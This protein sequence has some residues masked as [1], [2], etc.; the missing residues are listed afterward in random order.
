VLLWPLMG[1]WSVTLVLGLGFASLVAATLWTFPELRHGWWA[2][3]ALVNPALVEGL[4]LG[5][6]PFLW[7][8]AMF[9]AAIGCWRNNKRTAAIVLAAL[10][11]LTHAPVLIP[12]VA[13]QAGAPSRLAHQPR[14]RGAGCDRR[15]L[16]TRVGPELG[17]V[18]DVDRGRD[19]HA[20][21]T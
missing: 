11:Q 1:E 6:L 8:A 16:V 19:A 2:V 4:L 5:Q 12:L 14:R 15:A 20:A 3:A 7:A 18:H 9:V 21:C 17:A 13:R 10:A